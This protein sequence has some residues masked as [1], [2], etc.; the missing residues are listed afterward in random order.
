MSAAV[1]TNPD[2]LNQTVINSY[3]NQVNNS[4]LYKNVLTFK[5]ETEEYLSI[6]D[7]PEDWMTISETIWDNNLMLA[8]AENICQV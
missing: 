4:V 8:F 7:R 3:L 6:S 2:I 1:Q 5:G